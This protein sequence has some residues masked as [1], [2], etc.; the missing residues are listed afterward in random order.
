MAYTLNFIY[1]MKDF[2]IGIF[3]GFGIFLAIIVCIFCSYV[4]SIKAITN[5]NVEEMYHKQL[6]ITLDSILDARFGHNCCKEVIDS[7][8][9]TIIKGRFM[10]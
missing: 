6:V 10:F 4:G 2:F 7:D 5:S 9:V 1:N 8:S 3:I